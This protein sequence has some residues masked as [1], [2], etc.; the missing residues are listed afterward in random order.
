[1]TD[2]AIHVDAAA[3]QG[4]L[5]QL[6]TDQLPFATSVAINRT[7]KAVQAAIQA[8]MQQ[9][10]T[11]RRPW[12]LQGITIPRFSD[13]TDTPIAVSIEIDPKRAF[14]G[15]FEAGGVKTGS[16]TL[17]IAIPSTALRPDL[18]AVPPLALYPKNLGLVARRGVVGIRAPHS[19]LTK[20]GVLQTQGKART[21]VLDQTMIGVSVAGV[22]QRTGP[23]KHDIRL[24][25]S[26][27]DRIPIPAVLRFA[28]TAEETVRAEWPAIYQEAFAMAV[29][30]AK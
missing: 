4:W 6:F 24:L 19:H 26:Y 7:A 10:F 22:Y 18:S 13:K 2:Y 20:R 15:K 1:M 11:I 8:H 21:F 28:A 25:W 3:T 14:L 5:E 12:V 16:P 30:T 27:K 9:T 29:R 23:G 17:P